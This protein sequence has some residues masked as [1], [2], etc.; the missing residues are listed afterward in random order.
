MDH[1]LIKG[2]RKCNLKVPPYLF[3]KDSLELLKGNSNTFQ[4]FDEYIVSPEFGIPSDK[5]LHIGLFPQPYIGNLANATIFI[6]MLNP[7]F[8]P[9]NYF[10]EQNSPE[11]KKAYIRN[12]RQENS[13]DDYPFIFLNPKFSW[14]PGFG[15]WQ[16]KLQTIIEAHSKQSGTTYQESMRQISQK[17]VCLELFPY[18]SSGFGSNSLLNKLPS[19]VL[20]Q[21][22]V[23]D[24]VIP[25][26]QEDEAIIIVTRSIKNWN[27]PRHKNNIILYTHT[28][29]RSAS[30]SLIAS[31][32]G[33]AIAKHL[34]LSIK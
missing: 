4:K 2:W 33:K 22:Y 9:S 6:L 21:K 31:R 17:L 7:G 11:Y 3:P 10:I 16:R 12:L 20:M 5:S 28:E 25:K 30:L 14:H 34:G 29:T 32:G 27:L 18:P 19:V 23:R 1:E 26:V 24:L 15:Y 13:N 8:S